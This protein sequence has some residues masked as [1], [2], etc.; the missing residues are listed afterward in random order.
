MLNRRHFL[1]WTG[2][3]TLTLF[4]T[5]VAG[6]PIALAEAIPGGTLDPTTIPKFVTPL[7]IPRS[8]H[9]RGS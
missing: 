5:S 6:P 4:A 2:A 8:C 1:A 7:L 3:G 9:A